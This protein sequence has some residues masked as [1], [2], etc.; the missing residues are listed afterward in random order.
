MARVI[1][2]IKRLPLSIGSNGKEW[3][4]ASIGA[5][6]EVRD[7][8]SVVVLWDHFKRGKHRAASRF[9]FSIAFGTRPAI[10]ISRGG[11][12]KPFKSQLQGI[13]LLF[14]CLALPSVGFAKEPCGGTPLGEFV[15]Q[16]ALSLANMDLSA[17]D[18]RIWGTSAWRTM[19]AG[20]KPVQKVA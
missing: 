19:S 5:C 2:F 11:T 7:R 16:L 18:P 1:G 10:D 12:M 13:G 15:D 17:T 8:Y 20:R 6:A 4:I 3:G 9:R 14:A